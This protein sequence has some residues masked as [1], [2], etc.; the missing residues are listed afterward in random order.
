MKIAL[1][2]RRLDVKGGTQR[3]ALS[4]AQELVRRGQDVKLYTFS[5]DR[6][7]SYPDLLTGLPVASLGPD[8]REEPR[9]YR[10]LGRASGLAREHQ[11][12]RRLALL[13]DRDT[14]L[15]HPHDTVAYRVAYYFK[16]LG[17]KIP[18]VW[19][20][21]DLASARF[22]WRRASALGAPRPPLQAQLRAWLTDW[23][24]R[25][26]F[27]RAQDAITVLDHF[28]QRL[29]KE[30]FGLEGIV[31]RSGLDVGKFPYRARSGVDG[32]RVRIL[33]TGL[34]F[35]HR[36]F[37]DAIEATRILRDEWGYDSMLTIIGDT[38]ASPA[39]FEKLQRLVSAQNLEGR[40]TFAGE[41][42][43][44]GLREA[45][46]GHDAFVFPNELQTW[47]LA[48]FE[49]MSSGLPVIVSRGAGAH[50]VLT[51][52]K[53]AILV[54]PRD[55]MNIGRAIRALASDP[56]LYQALSVQGALFVRENISWPRYADGM[57]EVFR[58]VLRSP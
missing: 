3:Q 13:I 51:D 37:E 40:V 57:V 9:S 22:V 35:P 25:L 21:N 42:S 15:L 47:G 7:R 34:L 29:L 18:S 43:D 41:V 14:E 38:S 5:Y 56:K 48:V 27:L 6:E 11:M 28:N 30:Y 52:C 20:M 32:K 54:N 24:E 58:R 4:L 31:V 33:T 39:Y 49:A 55:A 46:H 44:A 16:R 45:Y 23:H 12:A 36:R 8:I 50:E 26:R 53:D 17:R 19:Q 1:I 2:V 10:Y